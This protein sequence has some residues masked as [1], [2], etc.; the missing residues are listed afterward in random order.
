ML[1]HSSF[2]AAVS[3]F[4]STT[5]SA[6]AQ[7]VE[8][9]FT[10]P[11]IT[12]QQQRDSNHS[13]SS[14]CVTAL[15]PRDNRLKQWSYRSRRKQLHS[16]NVFSPQTLLWHTARLFSLSP[17]LSFLFHGLFPTLLARMLL[18]R[19]LF[20]S[21][22]LSPLW[23]CMTKDSSALF[24]SLCNEKR[25]IVSCNCCTGTRVLG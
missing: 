16:A 3:I 9:N 22:F 19:F 8:S 17:S 14:A 24:I 11:G 20:I 4:I 18:D 7:E 13:L 25:S 5:H 12:K 15:L 2:H 10:L 6:A 1:H 21:S 23:T